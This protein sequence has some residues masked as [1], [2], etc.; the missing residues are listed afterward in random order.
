[1]YM[2]GP[3]HMWVGVDTLIHVQYTC[4]L[5]TQTQSERNTSKHIHY[6]NTDTHSQ[7]TDTSTHT[8]HKHRYTQSRHKHTHTLHKQTQTHAPHTGTKASFT[9]CDTYKHTHT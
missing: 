4:I 1:M 7:D 2:Y 3:T 9:D 5:Q 8:L 6:T